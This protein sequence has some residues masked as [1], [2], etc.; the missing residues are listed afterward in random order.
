[1]ARLQGVV[2]GEGEG[3]AAREEDGEGVLVVVQ[4]QAVVAQRAHAQPD[5]HRR[6]GRHSISTHAAN[7]VQSATLPQRRLWHVHVF[8]AQPHEPCRAPVSWSLSRQMYKKKLGRCDCV[9][10]E[11]C[12]QDQA[13][14]SGFVTLFG[15][16]CRGPTSPRGY[17]ACLQGHRTCAR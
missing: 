13:E 16:I 15:Y 10:G 11:G 6:Q 4:E 5:L 2:S 1:M 7:A 14:R 17:G 12:T 9:S 3:E 8:F